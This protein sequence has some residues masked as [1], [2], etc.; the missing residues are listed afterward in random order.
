MVSAICP[1]CHILLVEATTNSLANLGTAVNT[2]VRLGATEV[3]NSY[4][5]G[6]FSSEPTYENAFYKHP[7]VPTPA[8]SGDNGYGV[9]FP[10]ASQY[11]TAVG[12][13]SLSIVNGYWVESAW[14]G[15]GSGCSAYEPKPAWQKD[16]GC[17]SRHVAHGS[18]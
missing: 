12:G 18:A 9:Q 15:A 4:G 10:A 1:N 7:G 14:S 5:V 16:S 13:T 6:E 17:S 2:A 3:R 8:S 11:V